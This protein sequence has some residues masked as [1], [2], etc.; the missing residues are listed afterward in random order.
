MNYGYFFNQ[1]EPE[2]PILGMIAEEDQSAPYELDAKAVFAVDPVGFLVVEV[3]GCSCWPDRGS[4]TQTYCE[5]RIA[6]HRCIGE[7]WKSLYEECQT[8]DWKVQK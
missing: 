3:S 6:V 2:R 4:T 7:G 5:D 1:E 8:R